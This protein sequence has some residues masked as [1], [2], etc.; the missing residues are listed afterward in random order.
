MIRQQ[1]RR[2]ER[3]WAKIKVGDDCTKFLE[4]ENLFSMPHVIEFQATKI[5]KKQLRVR[6][7]GVFENHR[8]GGHIEL[9]SICEFVAGEFKVLSH[10]QIGVIPEGDFWEGEEIDDTCE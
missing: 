7:V 4:R 5:S 3:Q 9:V 2:I 1:R 8:Y 6:S 10:K